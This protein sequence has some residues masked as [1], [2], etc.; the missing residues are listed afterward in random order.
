MIDCVHVVIC[1]DG[2]ACM[3]IIIT[4]SVKCLTDG[5][6]L[7]PCNLFRASSALRSPLQSS[8]APFIGRPVFGRS[9]ALPFRHTAILALGRSAQQLCSARG[10]SVAQSSRGLRNSQLGARPCLRS[11][12]RHFG[13][14][15]ARALCSAALSHAR[16]VLEALSSTTLALS[17]FDRSATCRVQR[18]PALDH[19][20]ATISILYICSLN[21]HLCMQ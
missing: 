14:S 12:F 6:M 5:L 17:A 11:V 2:H 8:V 21:F 18:S 9:G 13:H 7:S 16:L 4:E 15:F 10:R 1:F 20:G 3:G 19:S